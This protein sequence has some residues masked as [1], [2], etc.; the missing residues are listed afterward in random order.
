MP[1]RNVQRKRIAANGEHPAS[2][3][4]ASL[5]WF[6]RVLLITGIAAVIGFLILIAG[7][8]LW[9][10]RNAWV[11]ALGAIITVMAAIICTVSSLNLIVQGFI[12]QCSCRHDSTPYLVHHCNC[13]HDF[14]PDLVRQPNRKQRRRPRKSLRITRGAASLASDSD[15]A[16]Q[17]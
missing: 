11:I 16:T 9:N 1:Y 8:Y 15:T 14:T 17:K 10:D 7:A 4:F 13:R 6:K 3:R 12:G 2:A 5:G